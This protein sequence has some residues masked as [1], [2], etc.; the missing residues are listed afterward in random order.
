MEEE[1]ELNYK[2]GYNLRRKCGRESLFE[3]LLF[4]SLSTTRKT[5]AVSFT[6]KGKVGRKSEEG[7]KEAKCDDACLYISIAFY[8]PS[9]L[10]PMTDFRLGFFSQGYFYSDRPGKRPF[11]LKTL[12]DSLLFHA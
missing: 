4:A 12:H 5:N 2:I 1:K 11:P 9:V 8:D 3:L 6:F 7:E 10:I